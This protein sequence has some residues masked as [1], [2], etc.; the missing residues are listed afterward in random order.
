M[1]SKFYVSLEAEKLL[2]EKGCPIE[3]KYANLQ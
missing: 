1:D 3:K 2:I